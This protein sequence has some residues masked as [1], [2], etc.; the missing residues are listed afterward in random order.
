VFN[1]MPLVLSFLLRP[2]LCFSFFFYFFFL[3]ISFTYSRF[4]FLNLSLIPSLVCTA[5]C[6]SV[7]EC[8]GLSGVIIYVSV[9]TAIIWVLCSNLPTF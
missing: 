3:I 6:V 8:S 7:Q 5:W 9:Y 4:H 2:F 1:C